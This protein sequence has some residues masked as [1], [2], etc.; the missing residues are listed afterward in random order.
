ME[1]EEL[2]KQLLDT[3]PEHLPE[4]PSEVPVAAPR[5]GRSNYISLYIMYHF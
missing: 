3:Q 2:D 5:A 1:Q 4:V